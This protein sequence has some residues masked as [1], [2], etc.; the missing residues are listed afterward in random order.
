MDYASYLIAL[1]PLET[2][3]TWASISLTVSLFFV[4]VRLLKRRKTFGNE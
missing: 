4:I 2:Q 1:I 3:I